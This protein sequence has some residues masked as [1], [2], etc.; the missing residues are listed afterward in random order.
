MPGGAAEAWPRV[1]N[2]LQTISAKAEGEPCCTWIS[3]G[4]SGHFVK[5][6]HNGIEYGDMQLIS[7]SYFLMKHLLGMNNEEIASTFSEWNKGP[8]DS[9]LIEI[10]SDILTSKDDMS[11]GYTI[12]AIMDTAGQKGTG[13]WTA[14]AALDLG[15]PLTLIGEAV[16][17]RCLSSQK[18]ERKTASSVLPGVTPNFEGDKKQFLQ[19]IHDALYASKIVSYAQGKDI[20]FLT[21]P[22]YPNRFFRF[23]IV[24]SCRS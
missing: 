18:E 14:I 21:S 19:D 4:G 15:M 23:R 8:L 9:Y 12:D 13:K 11:D 3:T 2:I 16:F 6:V 17:A 7:E 20:T 5:M 22:Q 10:T 1:K 24:A